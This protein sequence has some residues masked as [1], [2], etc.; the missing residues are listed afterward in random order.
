[1]ASLSS[2]EK[3]DILRCEQ[4]LK[5][6][7]G[8]VDPT[9][10][11][12]VYGTYTRPQKRKDS[13]KGKDEG[14]AQEKAVDSEHFQAV[15]NK[16]HAH[17]ADTLRYEQPEP[18]NQQL[19]DTLRLQPAAYLPGASLA[20]VCEHFRQNAG[21]FLGAGGE[22]IEEGYNCSPKTD[23]CLIIDDDSLD[24]IENGPEPIG[25][26]PPD[27][28]MPWTLKRN[29]SRVFVKLLSK[30]EFTM[31]EPKVLAAQGRGGIGQRVKWHGWCKFSPVYLMPVF[32]ETDK[33]DI[34]T[35]FKHPDKLITI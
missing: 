1:M 22:V 27:D 31:E 21:S 34:E 10:G 28:A 7:E 11:F 15:L 24:T 23:W 18:Y 3:H 20:D 13:D 12:Y 14:K 35:Y 33:G 2:W 17:A 29:A 4:F 6:I 25:P 16:L 30:N 32:N 9:W 26:M 19:I 8:W 5:R